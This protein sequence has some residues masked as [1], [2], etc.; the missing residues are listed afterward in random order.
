MSASVYDLLPVVSNVSGLLAVLMSVLSEDLWDEVF[1]PFLASV[2][3][4]VFVRITVEA[5]LALLEL[6]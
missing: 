6:C 3:L 4:R 2:N 5:D 1:L